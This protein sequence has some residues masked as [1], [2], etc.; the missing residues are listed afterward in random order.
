MASRT[1]SFD[2][3]DSA[4]GA[5]WPV[6]VR[7]SGAARERAAIAYLDRHDQLCGARHFGGGH[8]HVDLSVR[9]I[10]I[11]ALAFGAAAVVLAHNH[12]SGEAWPSRADREVTARLAHALRT[13]EVRLHDHW[14]AGARGG[15]WSFRAAGLL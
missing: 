14:I 15:W 3:T 11:D 7:V 6:L 2:W 9:R 13:L 1:I 12:P 4:A 8:G 5:A 10:A